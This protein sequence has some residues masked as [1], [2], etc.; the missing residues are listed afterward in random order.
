MSNSTKRYTMPASL[1]ISSH[2]FVESSA[3][4]LE[5]TPTVHW[6]E[7]LDIASAIVT[8][9]YRAIYRMVTARGPGFGLEWDE[10]AIARRSQPRL[11]VAD[12]L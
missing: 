9:P 10:N 3:H 2:I 8:E 1:P 12:A 7:H 6:L 4:L 11:I 5:I